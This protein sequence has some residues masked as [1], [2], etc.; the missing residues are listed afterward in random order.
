M[1]TVEP[2]WDCPHFL[3]WIPLSVLF[4]QIHLLEPNV[5]EWDVCQLTHVREG[6]IVLHFLAFNQT[7]KNLPKTLARN[8]KTTQL[9]M[10]KRSCGIPQP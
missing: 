2:L 6:R 7:A 5:T 8:A 4:E 1:V 10:F 9:L 3:V